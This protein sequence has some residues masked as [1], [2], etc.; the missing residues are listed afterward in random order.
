MV[1]LIAVVKV[2]AGVSIKFTIFILGLCVV[3]GG[4]TLFMQQML[5]NLHKQ[6]NDASGRISGFLQEVI[7]R[8]LIVQV[9]D[10]GEAM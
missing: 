5:K 4:G 1:E 6:I 8:L 10:V 3:L 7:E 2:L 9:L